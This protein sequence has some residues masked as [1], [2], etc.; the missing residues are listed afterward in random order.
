MPVA[1]NQVQVHCR[2]AGFTLL[3]VMVVLLIIAIVTALAVLTLDM[4]GSRQA[5]INLQQFDAKLR[6]SKQQAISQGQ[7]LQMRFTP[8]WV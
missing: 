7:T 1:A 3:E 6:F 8:L 4:S 2:H 5:R